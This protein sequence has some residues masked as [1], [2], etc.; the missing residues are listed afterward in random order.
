MSTPFDPRNRA[1]LHYSQ[2]GHG[3]AS[4]PGW[5]VYPTW[6]VVALGIFVV[7]VSI[8]IWSALG[9][10]VFNPADSSV[11]T[12]EG[13]DD[14]DGSNELVSVSG[15]ALDDVV[16]DACAGLP[17]VVHDGPSEYA[18]YIDYWY[19]VSEADTPMTEINF[20][21]HKNFEDVDERVPNI[22]WADAYFISELTDG[23]V[24]LGTVASFYREGRTS[25]TIDNANQIVD[26]LAAQYDLDVVK[27]PQDPDLQY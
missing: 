12:A 17:K 1:Q 7:I 13:G 18:T 5:S 10:A 4:G 24:V 26:Q 2:N 14:G 3:A 8:V 19:C 27:I 11:E 20:F 21:V 22:T 15:W 6:A 25:E 16:S 23:T 9:I